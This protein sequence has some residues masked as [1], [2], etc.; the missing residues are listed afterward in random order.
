MSSLSLPMRH[1]RAILAGA[2]VA[3][4]LLAAVPAAAEDAA[5]NIE[6][7]PVLNRPLLADLALSYSGEIDIRSDDLSWSDE[8]EVATELQFID[9]LTARSKEESRATRHYVKAQSTANGEISD[10]AIAGVKA[11]YTAKGEDVGVQLLE[12][13]ALTD[14][15]LEELLANYRS[16]GLPIAIPVG[17][18]VG[19]RVVIDLVPL[20]P[21]LAGLQDEVHAVADCVLDFFDSMSTEARLSGTTVI[22]GSDST[23]EVD[24]IMEVKGSIAI[25]CNLAQGRIASLR[26]DGTFALTGEAGESDAKVSGSGKYRAELTTAVGAAA[27]DAART[28]PKFRTRKYRAFR[29]GVGIKVPSHYS[30]LNVA[31]PNQAFARTVDHDKGVAVISLELLDQS[32]SNPN[33]LFDKVFGGLQAKHPGVMQE[34]VKNPLGGAEGRIYYIPKSS[35]DKE[36]DLFRSEFYPWRGKFLVLKLYGPPKAFRAAHAE[37]LKARETLRPLSPS[38]ARK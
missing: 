28:A 9:C 29:L 4:V 36:M 37:F 32:S 38:R 30:R 23:W 31:L 20:A 11:S 5:T 2:F 10:S 33:L 35:E 12:N 21:V 27:A 22:R 8:L 7:Q 3:A 1:D 15:L 17:T 13:R 19:Q 34:K 6:F 16:L 18:K 14:S 25:Q 26:I 24:A